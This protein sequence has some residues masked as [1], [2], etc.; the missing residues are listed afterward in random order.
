MSHEYAD[1]VCDTDTFI[2]PHL[3]RHCISFRNTRAKNC[4]NQNFQ[5]LKNFDTCDKGIIL[6]EII[7]KHVL[8]KILEIF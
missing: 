7:D 5:L 2:S 1:V 6:P 8:H 3:R 4:F